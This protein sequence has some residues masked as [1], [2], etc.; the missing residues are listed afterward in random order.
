MCHPYFAPLYIR[1][2]VAP[3]PQTATP[4]LPERAAATGYTWR[5]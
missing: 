4:A 3:H 5:V 2:R 1:K